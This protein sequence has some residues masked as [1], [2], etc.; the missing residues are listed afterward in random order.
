MRLLKITLAYDRLMQFKYLLDVDPSGRAA[1]ISWAKNNGHM[2]CPR[3]LDVD[4]WNESP[5]DHAASKGH[6]ICSRVYSVN[7]RITRL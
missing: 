1:A 7:P 4:C 3:F 2:G 5:T 6:A